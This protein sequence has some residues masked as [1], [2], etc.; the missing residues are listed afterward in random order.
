M[1]QQYR[2]RSGVENSRAK[3]WDKQIKI[4]INYKYT[5]TIQNNCHSHPQNE[6][7]KREKYIC[8]KKREKNEIFKNVGWGLPEMVKNNILEKRQVS[9]T[10]IPTHLPTSLS[11][12]TPLRSVILETCEHWDIWSELFL[13]KCILQK[14]IPIYSS[15]RL[16]WK[17][18]SSFKKFSRSLSVN[19]FCMQTLKI[20]FCRY[21]LHGIRTFCQ[22]V[23]QGRQMAT[24]ETFS[25]YQ[26]LLHLLDSWSDTRLYKC[27]Q[28]CHNL[29]LSRLF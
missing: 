4:K 27:V 11:Q 18:K 14:C 20:L 6:T 3:K 23:L 16:V 8:Y 26:L 5:T 15:L 19:S 10:F 29:A 7:L 28:S 12:R 24:E 1:L 2:W 22:Y 9:F 25:R 17:L 21:V 13:W